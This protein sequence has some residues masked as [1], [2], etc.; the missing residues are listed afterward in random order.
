MAIIIKILKKIIDKAFWFPF[1]LGLCGYWLLEG[2]PFWNSIYASVALYFVNPVVDESNGIILTAKLLAA[3]VTT[4]FLLGKLMDAWER[5]KHFF[6]NL[7]YNSACIYSDTELGDILA[8]SMPNSYLCKDIQNKKEFRSRDHIFMYS[9]EKKSLNTYLENKEKLLGKRVYIGLRDIDPFLLND[10]K[11]TDIHFFN[12]FELTARRYWAKYDLFDL[13]VVENKEVQIAIPICNRMG[14]EILRYGYLNNLYSTSQSIHYHVWGCNAHQKDYLEKLTMINRDKIHA[15][16]RE[17]RYDIRM[18]AEMDRIIITEENPVP[19]VEELLFVNSAARIFYFSERKLGFS[20][21]L[22]TKNIVE[23]GNVEDIFNDDSIRNEKLYQIAKYIHF[24]YCLTQDNN[25]DN[26][27][28][29]SDD[30]KEKMEKNWRELDGFLKGSNIARGD[31]CWIEFRLE[32]RSTAIEEIREVEHTRWCRFYYIN[33]W[34]HGETKNSEKRVHTLL[35]PYSELPDSEKV[36][37]AFN[38]DW[39]KDEIKKLLSENPDYSS[40]Q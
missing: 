6:I 26:N 19:T 4:T 32:E 35:V 21:V 2:V 10:E 8:K 7:S 12:P 30:Y 37:D 22:K 15:Y 23:F 25:A 36:K 18:I 38:F 14:M 29:D 1:L 34:T 27:A 16:D 28:I 5:M 20:H 13:V 9:D 40:L 39:I 33:N 11:S 3:L 17:W 31:H 24:D